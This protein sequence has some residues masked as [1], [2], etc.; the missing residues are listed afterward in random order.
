MKRLAFLI[1]SLVC[2]SFAFS[3]T[4]I[5][6]YDQMALV[7]SNVAIKDGNG[8]FMIPTTNGAIPESLLI[9]ANGTYEYHSAE[10]YT[11]DYFLK[12]FLGMIVQFEFTSG[13]TDIVKNVRILCANPVIIQNV[14]NGK[15]YFSPSGQFI[16]PSFPQIDS[17][18]YFIVSADASSLSYSYLTNGI[19]WK[20]YYT[21]NLD[22]GLMTGNVELWNKTDTTFRNFNLSILSGNPF[23]SSTN[24]PQVMKAFVAYMPSPSMPEE[25]SVEGYKI[26]NYGKVEALDSNST[27]FL[28]LFSKKVKVEK[29]NIVYNPSQNLTNAVQVSRVFHDFPVPAGTVSLY[30]TDNGVTYFL[31]QTNITDTASGISLELSYGQNFDLAAQSIE[32]QRTMVSKDLYNHYYQVTAI[33]SSSTSQSLWIYVSIPPDATV[34]SKPSVKFERTSTTQIRFYLDLGPNSKEVFTYGLQTSY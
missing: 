2:F 31:G 4:N 5:V 20:A 1:L 11:L 33:N 32:V 13:S 25:Q 6:V 14:E 30:K 9:S 8:T 22:N 24:Q 15:V 16:F 19:G 12:K 27:V 10:S 21:L 34:I 26:Y 29:L 18:N 17:Q 7:S 3:M 23:T 28:P